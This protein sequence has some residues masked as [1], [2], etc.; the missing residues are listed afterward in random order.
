[1]DIQELLTPRNLLIGGVAIVG[2]IIIASKLRPKE[3]VEAAPV[4]PLSITPV[5][6]ISDDQTDLN[7]RYPY[8][9]P[10]PPQPRTEPPI[11]PGRTPP[12]VPRTQPPAPPQPTPQPTGGGGD[13]FPL[14]PACGPGRHWDFNLRRC[15]P[16]VA[17]PPPPPQPPGTP[18]HVPPT[19]PPPRPP[20]V[21][22]PVVPGGFPTDC[23]GVIHRPADHPGA[24]V[25]PLIRAKGGGS[26]GR[27]IALEWAVMGI[28]NSG[29]TGL[30]R[31]TGWFNNRAVWGAINNTRR[32]RGLRAMTEPQFIQ[33]QSALN[34][35]N[36]QNGGRDDKLTDGQIQTLWNT[37]H[38]P[39]LCA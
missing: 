16:N 10:P 26:R 14:P 27:A 35:L 1:M 24:S 36:A 22:A 17:T 30:S 38:M 21:A 32:T 7:Q 15:V 9:P 2:G 13:T 23:R 18:R 11:I 39:F 29:H 37:Y 8:V 19:P 28:A 5:R 31:F 6:D 3:H 4:V 34:N 20:P 33:L 12:P 25:L